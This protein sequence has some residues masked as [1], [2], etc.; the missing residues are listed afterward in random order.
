MH[1]ISALN[2]HIDTIRT[3]ISIN[4]GKYAEYCYV[5]RI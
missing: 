1:E 4:D 2:M 3:D 5:F